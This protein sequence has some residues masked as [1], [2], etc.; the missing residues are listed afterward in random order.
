MQCSHVNIQLTYN[1]P[2]DRV[3]SCDK[4]LHAYLKLSRPL[5]LQLKPFLI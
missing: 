5:Q 2:D 4:S 3:I 1:F